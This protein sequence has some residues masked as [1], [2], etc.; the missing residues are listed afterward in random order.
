MMSGTVRGG[1]LSDLVDRIYLGTVLREEFFAISP[2][3]VGINI[4]SRVDTE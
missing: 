4:T 3:V 2:V 1:V